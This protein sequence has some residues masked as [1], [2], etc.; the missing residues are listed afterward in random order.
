MRKRSM[1]YRLIN[2]HKEMLSSI[3]TS[4]SMVIERWSV[5]NSAKVGASRF[6]KNKQIK[7]EML[8]DLHRNGVCPSHYAGRHLLNIGDTTSV[9]YSHIGRLRCNDKEIGLIEDN[10]SVGHLAHANVMIDAL[11][12]QSVGYGNLHLWSRPL[13]R[14]VNGGGHK[15]LPIEAKESHRWL[16]GSVQSASAYASASMITTI[17]DRES[18]IYELF[19]DFVGKTREHLLV[20]SSW[21]RLMENGELLD[22]HLAELRQCGVETYELEVPKTAKR[23]QRRAIMQ[24]TYAPVRLTRPKTKDK[25]YPPS[26]LLYAVEAIEISPIPAHE[27][28]IHWRLLTTHQVADFATASQIIRYYTQ[29][30]WIEDLFRLLKTQGLEVE[31]SQLS[32]GHALK[33]MLTTAFIAALAILNLRQAKQMNDL[34]TPANTVLTDDQIDFLKEYEP[35]LSG[36]TP[37]QQNPYPTQSL[38]WAAWLIARLGGWNPHSRKDDPKRSFGVIVLTRGWQKLDQMTSVWAWTKQKQAAHNVNKPNFI[39][40]G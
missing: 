37:L 1:D 27:E 26:V 35:Q 38:I 15:K 32:T 6:Y 2:R 31:S 39:T 8:I 23:S 7:Y 29:R 28:A 21:N 30:W 24:V 33:N 11:S 14:S 17:H 3:L 9:K 36:K 16:L 13:G 25:K 34:Q 4:G 10:Q 19:C 12:G 18:D 22:T 5:P 40:D 20:R